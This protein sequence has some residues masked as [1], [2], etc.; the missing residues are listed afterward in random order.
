MKKQ[1]G[2]IGAGLINQYCHIPA[3]NDQKNLDLNSICDL[4][5]NLLN[6]VFQKNSFKNKYTN[7]NEMLDNK[8]LDAIVLTVARKDTISILEKIYSQRNIKILCEKPFGLNSKIS[9]LLIKKYPSE[10]SNTMVGYMKKY[11]PAYLELKKIIINQKYGK[12]ISCNVKNSMGDSYCNPVNYFKRVNLKKYI[13]SIRLSK[14]ANFENYL[15]VFSHDFNLISDLI[16]KKTIIESVHMNKK[17]EGRVNLN[18]SSIPVSIDT[19]YNNKKRWYE[20]FNLNFTNAEIKLKFP[21]ALLI[22]QL[23]SLEIIEYKNNK[24]N[25]KNYESDWSFRIQAKIFSKFI[26]KKINNPSTPSDAI[27]DINLI[28]K[29]WKKI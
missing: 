18:I 22:N 28:E 3:I 13:Q 2:F 24:K 26:D 9:K 6:K 14:N 5:I 1:I 29:I 10:S 21:P 23:A 25:I 16:G 11:E 27:F 19:F 15:N 7:I 4:D 12:L 17:G 20:V 8:N